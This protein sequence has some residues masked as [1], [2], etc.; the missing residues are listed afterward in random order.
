[1][2]DTIWSLLTIVSDGVPSCCLP[3]E[4]DVDYYVTSAQQV[5][6]DDETSHLHHH[7]IVV[8]AAKHGIDTRYYVIEVGKAGS[9]ITESFPSLVDCFV[10]TLGSANVE[11]VNTLEMR[12]LDIVSVHEIVQYAGKFDSTSVPATPESCARFAERVLDMLD[13]HDQ[14]AATAERRA[15]M[16][17]ADAIVLGS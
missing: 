14:I 10:E 6:L 17:F 15:S 5:R 4:D 7:D 12:T 2:F 9:A 16:H 8:L 13:H 1:M 3:E 11:V